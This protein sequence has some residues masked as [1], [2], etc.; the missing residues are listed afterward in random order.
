MS[1]IYYNSDITKDA[2]YRT[3]VSTAMTI[4]DIKHIYD[5]N[6]NQIE[7]LIIGGGT[8]VFN[9][10]S[11]IEMKVYNLNDKVIYINQVKQKVVYLL[12]Y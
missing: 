6:P 5:K 9:L 12:V 4:A 11:Y 10:N 1:N 8:S 7:E 3:K 2:F